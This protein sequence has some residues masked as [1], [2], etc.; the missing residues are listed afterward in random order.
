LQFPWKP[1]L[2]AVSASVL[3]IYVN[4]KWIKYPNYEQYIY[5]LFY[6]WS[7]KFVDASEIRIILREK[8]YSYVFKVNIMTLVFIS[9][10]I[11]GTYNNSKR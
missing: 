5:G 7:H 1:Y 3:D 2:V 10:F 9:L 8:K 4:S 6:V 11:Q